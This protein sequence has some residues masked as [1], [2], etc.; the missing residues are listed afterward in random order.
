VR[1]VRQTREQIDSAIIDSAAEIFATHGF[2]GTSV[3]Q[4]ADA[5]GY[6]KTGLLHRFS[7]KKVLHDAV[8]N[9][10]QD[11]V[12]KVIARAGAI[13]D[14]S[15][16]LEKIIDLFTTEVLDRPSIVKLLL[17]SFRPTSEDP[18][19]HDLQGMAIR[20]VSSLGL[21][22]ATAEQRMR[23]ILALQLVVN[24]A[25]AELPGFEVDFDRRQLQVLIVELAT[26]VLREH[27]TVG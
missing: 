23:V 21:P 27:A 18:R 2:A 1:I 20:L 7:S 16:R 12:E 5:V 15:D 26:G 14:G 3:Q 19:R 10:A 8:I 22:L 25:G 24:A 6:S 4:I 9:E 13:E 11:T 17:E